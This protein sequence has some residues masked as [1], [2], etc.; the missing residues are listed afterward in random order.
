MPELPDVEAIRNYVD[1]TS[2]DKKIAR[3]EVKSR[4][5]LTVS[6]QKF[7]SRLKGTTLKSTS[8]RGKHLF[9]KTDKDLWITM[10]FGMTGDLKFVEDGS[11]EV[12]HGQVNIF[13]DGGQKLSYTSLRKLGRI[14]LTEDIDAYIKRKKLGPDADSISFGEF[15]DIVQ[16]GKG[17]IKALLMNQKLVSGIGNIYSDEMLFQAGIHPESAASA[18]GKA[19]VR[20]LYDKMRRIFRTTIKRGAD[21]DKYPSSYLLKSRRQGEECPGCSGKVKRETIAGRSSYFCPGCQR[22]IT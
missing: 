1:A 16:K 5:M 14:G 2:L 12:A 18:L 11:E 17:G 22:K 9:V 19:D 6:G 4:R 3:V 20:K 15:S 13:F 8:R 7:R 10:H 21:S